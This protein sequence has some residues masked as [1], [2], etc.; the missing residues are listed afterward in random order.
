MDP[1][2]VLLVDDEEDIR[3]GISRKMDWEGL[4]FTLVGEAEN[5]RDALDLAESLQPDVVLTDIKMPF[6]DGLELCRI[7]T[8]RLPASKFVVFSGFD[9]FEYAKQAIQMKVFE[10]ILKPI[11][12]AELAAV[13]QKLKT[14]LDTERTQRQDLANLRQRYEESLPILR[15]LYFTHLLEGSIPAGQEAERA[16]RLDISLTGQAWVAALGHI[17]GST[18]GGR[19]MQIL[20]VQ[21]LAEEHFLLEGCVCRAFPHNDTLALVAGLREG[22][23]IYEFIEAV[24]RICALTESYLGLTLTMGVGIPCGELS[25]LP[26]SADGARS[27]LDYR[28]MVGTGRAIYIGDL[29]PD[30]G[31]TLSF[32]EADDRELS[33]AVKLGDEQEV[34][35]VV[36]RL[37]DKIRA[38]GMPQA[39][40]SLFFLELLTCLLKLTRSADLPLEE[41][42]GAGFTGNVQVTDF[43]TVEALRSWCLERCLRIRSLLRRRR[44]DSAGQT[45]E[46]AKAYIQEHYSESDLSVERLCG[47]LHLSPTY[48]STLFKRETGMSFTTC[49]TEVRMAAAAEALRNTEEK[50]Y[51]IAQHCGYDD[52]NYF[53]YVFKRCFGMSPTKY[54]AG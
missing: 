37:T 30:L 13:L 25:G 27:A 51:L 45:V 43:P 39:Q 28:G 19:D 38:S 12:A 24:N 35:S 21:Q 18:G 8:D 48:F 29:E 17:D 15:G 47:Y 3:V 54:R 31:G 9:D 23:S 44:T 11:N 36:D 33:A 1:Y 40:C 20:S 26:Q 41:V 32:D 42:F 5:G 22:V 52:P 6:M 10:Y 53:S 16:A 50:T 14:Q 4:G 34:R 7:L 49:V 2:R 46:R